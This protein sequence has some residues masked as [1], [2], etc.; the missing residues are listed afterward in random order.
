M[1]ELKTIKEYL[2]NGRLLLNLLNG[3]NFYNFGDL[4]YDY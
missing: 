2:P 1:D 3:S 4:K